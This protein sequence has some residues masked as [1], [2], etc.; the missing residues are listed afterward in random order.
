MDGTQ[1]LL[2]DC[3]TLVDSWHTL[4]VCAANVLSSVS[5]T[6]RKIV[7]KSPGSALFV[8]CT[9]TKTQSHIITVLLTLEANEE[10]VQKKKQLASE[11][12]VQSAT[13]DL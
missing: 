2:T 3:N 8:A 5:P 13:V 12:E 11:S 4:S 9:C 1:K 6:F 10:T 7:F